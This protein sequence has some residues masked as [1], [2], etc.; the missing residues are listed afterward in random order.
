MTQDSTEGPTAARVTVRGD[1]Q[2]V[3]YRYYAQRRAEE[4]GLV[5]WI[6]NQTDG[7]V[8]AHVE[9]PSDA[10][11]AMVAWCGEGSPAAHVE[12]VARADAR[13]EGGTSFEARG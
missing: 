9:G 10:V 12:D 1:V 3:S 8:E 13:P 11:E 5:G 7:S 4:L 6:R 2:G